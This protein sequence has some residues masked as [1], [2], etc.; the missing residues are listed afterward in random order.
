MIENLQLV[1]L[2]LRMTRPTT[3]PIFA[4]S[5]SAMMVLVLSIMTPTTTLNTVLLTAN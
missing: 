3:A 5:V 4:A 1:V 2:P